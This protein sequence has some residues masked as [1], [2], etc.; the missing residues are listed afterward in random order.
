ME[1]RKSTHKLQR[2]KS[3]TLIKYAADLPLVNR[4]ISR[5]KRAK[6]WCEEIPKYI[7]PTATP[8]NLGYQAINEQ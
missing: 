5:E 8:G 1:E 3:A 6:P 4:K 7:K 2:S